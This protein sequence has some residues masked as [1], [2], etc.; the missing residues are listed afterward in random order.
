MQQLGLLPRQ[1]VCRALV[2]VQEHRLLEVLVREVQPE[3]LVR[4]VQVVPLLLE[5]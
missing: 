1:V 5:V 2:E 3:H 4:V